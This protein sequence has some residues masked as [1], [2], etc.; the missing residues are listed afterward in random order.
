MGFVAGSAGFEAEEEEED[1]MSE[2][3]DGMTWSICRLRK[4]L[5]ERSI[6]ET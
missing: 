6:E 1:M 2:G 3:L 4:P 5:F